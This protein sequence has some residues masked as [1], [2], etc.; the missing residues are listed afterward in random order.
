V[1]K[2]A[3]SKNGTGADGISD[4]EAQTLQWVKN[5]E[6]HKKLTGLTTMDKIDIAEG[7]KDKLFDSV[8]HKEI[9]TTDASQ[10]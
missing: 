10:K 6:S 4:K 5:I 7:T 9:N 8:S 3:S 2:P 1:N